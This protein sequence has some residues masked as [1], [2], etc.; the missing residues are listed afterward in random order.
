[1]IIEDGIFVEIKDKVQV[2]IPD[3][4]LEDFKYNKDENNFVSKTEKNRP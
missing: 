4:Y 1:M 2:V 3:T